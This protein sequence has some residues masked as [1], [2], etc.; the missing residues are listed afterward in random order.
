MKLNQFEGPFD[1]LVYLIESAEMNIYDI[2]ISEIT[3]QYLAHIRLMEEHDVMVDAEFLVLAA[4]LI[5]IKSK[6]LLPRITPEG[7]EVEDPREGLTQRLVEYVQYKRRAAALEE[8]MDA[9]SMK[10][11]KPQEDLTPWTGEPD[12]YLNM[13]MEMFMSAFRAFIY[14]R[15]KNEEMRQ[16]REH[17]EREKMSVVKKKTFIE[18]ILRAAIGGIVRFRE[19][20]A[21]EASKYDKV[22]TF[23]SLL[24]LVKSGAC[25]VRQEG[26]FR[27]IEVERVAK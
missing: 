10:H 23:V 26:N 20:L 24:E 12:E 25:S 13:D 5:E 19:L 3:S 11:A 18:R 17:I 15:Q 21:P 4:T 8:L 22:V 6:M 16:M 2:R 27:E 1:L 7:E 14:K 9:A